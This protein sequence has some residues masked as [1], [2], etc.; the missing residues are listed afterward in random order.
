MPT[1]LYSEEEAEKSEEES[2]S[3]ED[4]EKWTNKQIYGKTLKKVAAMQNVATTAGAGRTHVNAAQVKNI[5]HL[6]FRI[7]NDSPRVKAAVKKGI[8]QLRKH[9]NHKG[10]KFTAQFGRKRKNS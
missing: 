5:R 4:I 3:D 1:R 7:E 2:S 8:G 6:K 9:P 10:W